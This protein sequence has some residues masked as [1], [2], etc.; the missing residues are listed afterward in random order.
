MKY[1]KIIQDGTFI[2]VVTSN[3]FV[4]YQTKHGVFIS[5]TE[6]RGEFIEYNNKLYRGTWMTPSK[7]NTE[8]VFEIADVIEVTEEYYNQ[9]KTAIDNNEVVNS[10]YEVIPVPKPVD[11]IEQ[12]GIDFIRETKISEM[13]GTCRKT[14]ENGFDLNVHGETRH[15]SLDTQDQLNLMSLSVMAETESLIPYHADGEE[16]IFYTAQEIKEIVNAANTFKIYH[17]TYYNALKKY[18]NALTTIQ[19]IVAITYGTPIPEEYQ[20]D[21]LKTFNT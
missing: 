3:N 2:G 11:A 21:V 12:L 10:G 15:F 20:S 8:G 5:T 16:V 14:I 1:Y 18:I 17:T 6:R 13:S 9:F 4:R 19:E 7:F